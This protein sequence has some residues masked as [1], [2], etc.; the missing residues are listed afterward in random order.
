MIAQIE[1]LV[2]LETLVSD[3]VFLNVDLQLLSALL[4]MR[5]AGLAHEADS[6]DAPGD[7]H[8]DPRIFQLLG[9]LAVILGTNVGNRVRELVFRG[10]RPLAQSF[11]LFQLFAPQFVD[12]LVESQKVP[13]VSEVRLGEQRL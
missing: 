13:C 1:K 12:F 11:N 6:H 8:V 10:I 3:R 9:S 2:E 5:E 4:Q 7:A